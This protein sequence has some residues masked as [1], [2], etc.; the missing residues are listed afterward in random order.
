MSS[1]AHIEA[2]AALQSAPA[3]AGDETLSVVRTGKNKLCMSS[4]W[5]RAD[6]DSYSQCLHIPHKLLNGMQMHMHPLS[7]L[8][9]LH[10]GLQLLSH[11]ASV[12]Q[13]HRCH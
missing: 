3:P 11:S 1:T 7:T 4:W 5:V 6:T 2:N 10:K 12:T 9:L 13:R 8:I